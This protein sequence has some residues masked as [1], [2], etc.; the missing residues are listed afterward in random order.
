M[1]IPHENGWEGT[2]TSRRDCTEYY[3]IQFSS[4]WLAADH[5]PAHLY[6]HVRV[7]ETWHILVDKPFIGGGN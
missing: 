3:Y 4:V 2:N 5:P 7:R 1:S 6:L